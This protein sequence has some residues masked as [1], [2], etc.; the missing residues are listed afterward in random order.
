VL[1]PHFS[2]L[3][4]VLIIGGFVFALGFLALLVLKETYGKD[5][6]FLEESN[7]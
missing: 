6:D 5:L 2:I 1:K 3:Q 4:T 7:S